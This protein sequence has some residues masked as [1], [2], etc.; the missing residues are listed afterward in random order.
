MKMITPIKAISFLLFAFCF[1]LSS[2]AQKPDYVRTPNGPNTIVDWN[3]KAK[4]LIIPHG[5]SLTISGAQD[6]T[7]QIRMLIN[8]GV[9]TSLYMYVKPAV[10]AGFWKP[11]SKGGTSSLYV[12]KID[13]TN[14][15]GYVTRTALLDSLAAFSNY[16]YTRDFINNGSLA[17]PFAL[18]TNIDSARIAL[19]NPSGK[20][21]AGIYVRSVKTDTIHVPSTGLYIQ[22]SGG[23]LKTDSISLFAGPDIG[24]LSGHIF[25]QS[26]ATVQNQLR[27]NTF[28]FASKSDTT[29]K[30]L[31]IQAKADSI[32]FTGT[33]AITMA[34]LE[35]HT[36]ALQVARDPVN[37]DDAIPLRYFNT[38]GTGTSP[39]SIITGLQLGLFNGNQLSVSPGSWRIAGTGYS[40]ATSTFFTLPARD[41]TQSRYYT[42]YATTGNNVSSIIGALSGTPLVPPIPANSVLIGSALITPT[43]T[44]LVPVNPNTIYTHSDSLRNDITV[45]FRY[46]KLFMGDSLLNKS[47]L[48]IDPVNNLLVASTTNGLNTSAL[49]MN[50]DNSILS[51]KDTLNNQGTLLLGPQSSG[52]SQDVLGVTKYA[53]YYDM[54][55]PAAVFLDNQNYRGIDYAADYTPGPHTL[56][57]K[58][59]ADSLYSGSSITASEGLTIVG[60]DV[61]MG[62]MLSSTMSIDVN[63]NEFAVGPS[64]VAGSFLDIQSASAK[65]MYD[66]AGGLLYGVGAANNYAFL[67]KT[68]NGL[69]A[70]RGILEDGTNLNVTDGIGAVGLLADGTI[71]TAKMSLANNV[72]VTSGWVDNRIVN[73]VANATPPQTGHAGDFLTTNGTITSWAT[74]PSSVNIGNAD[75]TLTGNRLL[76]GLGYT[77]KINSVSGTD[78]TFYFQQANFAFIRSY[79]TATNISATASTNNTGQASLAIL[80]NSTNDFS[81]V[82]A[83]LASSKYA[84]LLRAVQSSK[85]VGIHL[86]DA[87]LPG[88]FVRDQRWHFGLHADSSSINGNTVASNQYNYLYKRVADSLYAPAAG[89]T[90]TLS[91]DVSG[92]GTSAITTAIGAGKVTN[93]MLAGSIAASKLVGTDITTVG[94]LSAGSIP[95]SLLTGTPTVPAAANPTNLIT[96]TAA[97]GVATTYE[98]SDAT[99]AADSSIIRS[100]ANSYS[101]AGMQTKLNNYALTS[102][103][104]TGANPTA[105]AGTSPVNGSSLTFMRSDAAPKVDSSIFQ[106]V[107][108]YFPKGDTRYLQKAATTLPASF[109]S[110]SLTSVGTLANLTVTNAPTFSFL[111]AGSI[112]FAGAAGLLSQDNNNFYYDGTNHRVSFGTNGDQTGTNT[113][114]IYG[115]YDAYEPQSAIGIVTD[116]SVTPGISASTSRGTGAS[117]VINNTGDLI[118]VHSFFAYTGASPAYKFF[119]GVGGKAVGATANELGGQLDFYTKADGS[120]TVTSWETIANDG[121]ITLAKYGAGV[122]HLSSGGVVSSSTVTNAELANSTIS[123]VSLGGTLANLTATDASLTF[124]GT[125]TGGTARTIGLNSA[126]ANTFTAVQTVNLTGLGTSPAV[127]F[128]GETTTAAALGAQQYGQIIASQGN[129]W[130]TG[131]SASQT[132]A[133]GIMNLPV[134]GTNMTS[135]LHFMTNQNGAG[136]TQTGA[137]IGS[138]GSA[139][140][141]KVTIGAGG[142]GFAPLNLTSGTDLTSPTAGSIEYNGT[143]FTMNPSTT[144]KRVV[145]SNDV[146]PSNGQIPIGD[147]TNYLAGSL[148]GGS[149]SGMTIVGGSGSVTFSIQDLVQTATDANTTVT[150]V[151][152]MVKL[153]VITAARTLTLPAQATGKQIKIWNQNTSGTFLWTFATTVKDKTNSTITAI[154]NQSWVILESDGTNWLQVSP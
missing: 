66:D 90:I 7:G 12:Q 67:G 72:Y 137:F 87:N 81:G 38:H 25:G 94:T 113:V 5:P 148:T 37:D 40:K 102:A 42:A 124:S 143:R 48:T 82:L 154:A 44:F 21:L 122:A 92:S 133:M 95:Y 2:M 76:E 152:S 31:K 69:L 70:Q 125:Y 64:G 59:M 57:D 24:F 22:N 51:S 73:R 146:A 75:L 144:R 140:F 126:N 79:S 134:Q 88:A 3:L 104:P 11:V 71:D 1:S 138:G 47:Y 120:A 89:V 96:Y 46:N 29:T 15:P 56:L 139:G 65:L 62:G 36:G 151:W 99:H 118:G 55:I 4:T 106:T 93:T 16:F 108:N 74:L 119:A 32:Y 34:Q 105:T 6:S 107:L 19:L 128:L 50:A 52:I 13:S 80:N 132:S 117:P 136:W 18:N 149:G 26:A 43:G 135:T 114:N 35:R 78:S 100:V 17:H 110:S 131:S 23:R 27:P 150:N 53:F 9:D 121:T 68:D 101:L 123:G 30:Y 45:F 115:V 8:P 147:G 130:N 58:H 145:L 84:L 20:Q 14:I 98:R 153:P 54:T 142:T 33:N 49:S 28:W 10:G 77:F 63:G 141:N 116:P 111:T 127:A 97:N 91:G 41:L 109:L 129:G 112:P 60:S 61:R 39:T 83:T 85:E 86:N 103:L